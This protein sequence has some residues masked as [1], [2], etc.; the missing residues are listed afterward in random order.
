M[1]C[2]PL[3]VERNRVGHVDAQD[4]QGVGEVR[5]GEQRN[6]PPPAEYPNEDHEPH[7]EHQEHHM[8]EVRARPWHQQGPAGL[9]RV[10]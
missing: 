7:D 3:E 9:P 8:S 1:S 6:P 10:P 5:E 4:E 2:L